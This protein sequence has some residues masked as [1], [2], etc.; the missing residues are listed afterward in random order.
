MTLRTNL[1]LMGNK[2]GIEISDFTAEEM[3]TLWGISKEA[4]EIAKVEAEKMI[5]GL[6]NGEI[7]SDTN[8]LMDYIQNLVKRSCELVGDSSVDLAKTVKKVMITFEEL[9][10]KED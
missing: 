8:I 4:R 5:E 6:R 2:V 9:D 10:K 1:N 7:Q 3:T